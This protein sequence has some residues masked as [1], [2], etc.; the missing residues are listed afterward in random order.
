MTSPP[1]YNATDVTFVTGVYVYR[2]QAITMA[3]MAARNA[4]DN[5]VRQLA[6]T[7]R[8]VE[9]STI[10]ELAGWLRAWGKPVPGQAAPDTGS[11]LPGA[12]SQAELSALAR[13]S[14]KDFDKAYLRLLTRN[15]QGVIKLA[16][17]EQAAGAA[18]P[19]RQLASSLAATATALIASIREIGERL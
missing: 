1:A 12:A 17:L 10:A 16:T 18:G 11:D 8:R 2:R 14:K 4:E 3:D 6:G 15:Q 5:G 7:M 9:Q 13:L 19:P